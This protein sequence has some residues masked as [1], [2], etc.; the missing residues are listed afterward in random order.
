MKIIRNI[1][2][3]LFLYSCPVLVFG[4]A[5]TVQG[6]VFDKDS[7]QRVGKVFVKNES[8][9]ENI[10]NNARGEFEISVSVGDKIVAE[11]EGFYGDT[12]LYTGQKIL[13]IYVARK[14][15]YI[16]EVRV[17]ARRSPEEILKQRREDFSKAYKL[18]DPGSVFS[19]GP[20]GA[21]VSIN[22]IYSLFSKEVKQAKRLTKVIQQEYEQNVIDSKFT[23]DLVSNLTGLS[24]EQLNNFMINY[25]PTYY[26]VLA[27]SPYDL[28][29]YI[30]SK[31]EMFKLNPNLRLLPKLPDLD[32]EVNN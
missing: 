14:S 17:V 31:Y 1:I 2:L 5:F 4:Q 23:P 27:A 12:I 8:T 16:P 15:I 10:F 21:G 26:F 19:V 13:L 29:S 7:N 30:Q 11:K 9:R 18:S 22:A 28:T 20:T 6:I 24:G 32:L 25:R 3:C